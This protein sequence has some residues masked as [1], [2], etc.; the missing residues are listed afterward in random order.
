M[1]VRAA[2]LFGIGIGIFIGRVITAVAVKVNPY[3]FFGTDSTM[4]KKE[5]AGNGSAFVSGFIWG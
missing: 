1:E 5:A 2:F 4:D 3:M